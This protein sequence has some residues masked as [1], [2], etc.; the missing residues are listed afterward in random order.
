MTN[1]NSKQSDESEAINNEENRIEE[2]KIEEPVAEA[3][4]I[5]NSA[6]DYKKVIEQLNDKM[7]R[8]MADAQ[9]TRHRAEQDIQKARLF[10]IESFAKD[11][12]S[13]LDNLQRASESISDNDGTEDNSL[14]NVREGIEITKKELINALEKNNI[15]A[16]NPKGQA[17]DPNIHQA[18]VQVED[19]DHKA[20]IVVDVMQIGYTIN[21][22]VLRPALV[23][24][25]K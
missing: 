19:K 4:D 22:R 18:M 20:G 2:N 16:V 5:V 21:D 6:E 7:L 17:F 3:E 25:A 12:L 10:S 11:I 9:N 15:K 14:Q 23:A 8:A 1:K 13:V 24:V